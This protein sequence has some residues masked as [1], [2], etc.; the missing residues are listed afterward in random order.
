MGGGSSGRG[1]GSGSNSSKINW[2][3]QRKHDKSSKQYVEGKSC[4][5]MQKTAMQSFIDGNLP[6]AQKIGDNKYRVHSDKVIGMYL[7][8]HG[9]AYPTTNAII[10]TSKTGSHMYPSRPD[11]YKGE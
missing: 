1:N 8:K 9:N 7:D 5:T 3:K 2:D 6:K 11:N 10:I 4:I